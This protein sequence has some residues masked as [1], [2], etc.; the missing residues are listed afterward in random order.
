M[1]RLTL[2][3]PEDAEAVAALR[4]AAAE[5]L[6]RRFGRGHWSHAVS[7][8]SV[9]RSMRA[10]KVFV[11]RRRGRLVGTVCLTTKKPWA[12]DPSF[13]SPVPR[14]LYLIEMAVAP[15]LQGQGIGRRCLAEI[16]EIARSWPADSLRLDAYEGR[17]GAGGFYGRC[18]YENVGRRTY[19]QVPLVY[20]ESIVNADAV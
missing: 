10:G 1:R 15:D 11:L 14:P 19:R 2:A 7:E 12:I 17:A 4:T 3:T 6:T 16:E 20:Y 8:G 5:N 18:G 9:L 13:F